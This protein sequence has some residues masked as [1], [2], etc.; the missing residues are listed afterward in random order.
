MHGASIGLSIY[1]K[2]NTPKTEQTSCTGRQLV[3]PFK[4]RKTHLRQSR[5]LAWCVNWSVHLQKGKH[6]QDRADFLH[7]VSTGLSIHKQENTR[8]TEQTSCMVRHLVC[9]FTNRKTHP[10]QSRLLA[11]CVNS[12]SIHTQENTPNI[13]QTSRMVRPGRS[14]K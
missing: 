4:K 10:R 12:M 14:S 8:K 6:T 13:E 2:K 11:W 3:C 1:R 5:L 9:P 7:W